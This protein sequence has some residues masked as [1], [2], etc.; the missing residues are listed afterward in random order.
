MGKTAVFVLTVLNRLSEFEG[1]E[2]PH[3]LVLAHTRELAFQIAKTFDRFSQNTSYKTGVII[4]GESQDDQ[5]EFLKKNKPQIIVGTPGRTLSFIKKGVIETKNIKVF[6]IDECD[7]MLQE[8]G[9]SAFKD[10]RFQSR[11]TS[12]IQDHT[13]Q[14]AGNDV[15]SHTPSRY[16][17]C[18]QNVHEQAF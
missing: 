8:L 9:N 12:N 2:G 17:R 6:I 18:L 13:A 14:K 10:F 15:F 7:K 4:G 5:M 16:Q 3:C 1:Q 11:C